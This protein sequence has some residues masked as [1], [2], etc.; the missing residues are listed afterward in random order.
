MNSKILITDSF[1]NISGSASFDAGWGTPTGYRINVALPDVLSAKLGLSM[2][3]P[4]NQAAMY[5]ASIAGSLGVSAANPGAASVSGVAGFALPFAG[6]NFEKNR[7]SGGIAVPLGPVTFA[8]FIV[9]QNGGISSSAILNAGFDFG[10]YRIS[11]GSAGI[12][13]SSA[14]S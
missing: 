12:K 8:P 9:N 7:R 1:G 2:S 11:F 3:G 14:E 6:I 5:A 10:G 4:L 13:I